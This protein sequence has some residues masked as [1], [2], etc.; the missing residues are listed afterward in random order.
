MLIFSENLDTLHS[1]G[2]NIQPRFDPLCKIKHAYPPHQHINLFWSLI[3]HV[4][5][6]TILKQKLNINYYQ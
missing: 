1:I 6:S 4:Y 5:Q 3:A 2:S